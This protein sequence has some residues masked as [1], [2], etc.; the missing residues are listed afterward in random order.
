M[1]N[2]EKGK[3][4]FQTVEKS[5]S[6]NGLTPAQTNH[7][8]GGHWIVQESNGR[9]TQQ[10]NSR[11]QA[12]DLADE[13]PGTHVALFMKGVT[14]DP[15]HA[16]RLAK[17]SGDLARAIGEEDV[18]RVE[19]SATHNKEQGYHEVSNLTFYDINGEDISP[20]N[21]DYYELVDSVESGV[22]NDDMALL[23][24]TMDN[25]VVKIR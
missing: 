19:F 7:D 6:A 5:A 25:I 17:I 8:I 22:S 11:E 9:L 10:T 18:A 24:N 23:V 1:T 12:E 16:R 13:N 2:V 3:K 14:N 21:E 15:A 4:G 20:D